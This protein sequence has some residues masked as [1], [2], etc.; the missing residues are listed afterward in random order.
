M[1]VDALGVRRDGQRV[2]I[3]SDRRDRRGVG[4]RVREPRRR[5]RC[6]ALLRRGAGARD[7]LAT[8][9]KSWRLPRQVN[10]DG[11][12]V[13]LAPNTWLVAEVDGSLSLTVG[14][15]LGYDVSFMREL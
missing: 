8:T 3:V 7:V 11:A 14:A 13:N 1:D 15:R 2:R 9:S 6:H 4:R 10:F 12:D 5:V